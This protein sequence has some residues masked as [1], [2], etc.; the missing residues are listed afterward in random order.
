MVLCAWGGGLKPRARPQQVTN[1]EAGTEG[2]G[3]RPSSETQGVPQQ[4]EALGSHDRQAWRG[5]LT[6]APATLGSVAHMLTHTHAYSHV[7]L[8]LI[9]RSCMQSTVQSHTYS[10][11]HAGQLIVPWSCSDLLPHTCSEMP[12]HTHSHAHLLTQI[13]P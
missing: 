13:N 1:S 5:W 8:Q 6:T 3:P 10:H 2:C 9:S 7:L 12:L 4:P 11:S